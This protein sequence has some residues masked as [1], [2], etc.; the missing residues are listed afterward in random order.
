MALSRV[1]LVSIRA[2]YAEQLFAQQKRVE[3]RRIRPGVSAGD[4]LLVYVPSPVKALVGRITIDHVLAA[5]LEDLWLAV[6]DV[7]GIT[8]ADF[9][10]YYTGASRGYGIFV[11]EPR[12]FVEPVGL[13]RIRTLCP[14]FHPP[15]GYHYLHRGRPDQEILLSLAES[16]LVKPRFAQSGHSLAPC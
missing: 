10:G 15:Q 8:R 1:L 3:L 14:R 6:R 4:S 16:E 11:L 13:R 2:R 9:D 7:A 5:P 12:R